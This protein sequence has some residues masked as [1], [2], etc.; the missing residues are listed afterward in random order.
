MPQPIRFAFAARGKGKYARPV[1]SL[2]VSGA[3]LL[4]AVWAGAPAALAQTI[5]LP[6]AASGRPTGDEQ[7]VAARI[8]VI[9]ARDARRVVELRL[10]AMR[11]RI[12]AIDAGLEDLPKSAREDVLARGATAAE[13]HPQEVLDIASSDRGH[14]PSN[15]QNRVSERLRHRDRAVSVETP[16]DLLE[17]VEALGEEAGKWRRNREKDRQAIAQIELKTDHLELAI[18]GIEDGLRLVRKRPGRVTY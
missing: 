14:R 13:S 5:G 7:Y 4:A 9:D 2:N 15:S 1:S 6:A 17:R 11:A 18:A 16:D 8:D 10:A 3:I 12:E